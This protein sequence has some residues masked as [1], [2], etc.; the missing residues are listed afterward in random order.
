MCVDQK[1]SLAV[2]LLG[3][4]SA[5]YIARHR[6]PETTFTATVLV[7]VS[8][9]QLIEMFIWMD[10]HCGKMNQIASIMICV[11]LLLQPLISLLVIKHLAGT[12]KLPLIHQRGLRVA[13]TAIIITGLWFLYLVLRTGREARCSRK[14]PDSNRL[15]WA[16]LR[17]LMEHNQPLVAIVIILVYMLTFGYALYL[18][19]YVF[20]ISTHKTLSGGCVM[21]GGLMASLVYSYIYHRKKFYLIW[22]ST[23]C[24]LVVFAGVA[25]VIQYE[26]S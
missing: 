9:M 3:V 14:D 4:G 21:W 12:S 18:T 2:F 10:P 20:G 6:T 11:V 5:V 22:G 23:W 19:R 16:P 26:L 25:S 1:T 8:C 24:F 7:L 13:I 15:Q 17:I